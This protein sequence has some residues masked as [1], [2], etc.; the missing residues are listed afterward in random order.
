MSEETKE[1]PFCGEDIPA[2]ASQCE[3]CEEFTGDLA[4]PS[5]S[6]DID[7]EAETTLWAGHPSYLGYIVYYIFGVIFIVL[8]SLHW[9][10]LFWGVVLGASLIMFSIFDRNSKVYA[11]TNVRIRVKAN[12]HRYTDEVLIK[13]ITSINLQRRAVEKLFGL[14]T[15]KVGSEDAVEDEVE[16]NV[17]VAFR[18]IAN[19]Q[20]IMEKIEGLRDKQKN[21]L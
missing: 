17:E 4:N 19:P 6:Q 12:I 15:V 11:I 9:F 20:E 5:T 21:H 1:C 3:H 18:G 7:E 14:G 16:T 10:F 8:G 2:V 13:D